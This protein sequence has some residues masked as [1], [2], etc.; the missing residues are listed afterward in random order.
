[1]SPVPRR[2]RRSSVASV[3]A[4]WLT[5]VEPNGPFLT[6]PVLR[7]VWPNGLDHLDTQARAEVR[8]HVADL[9]TADAASVTK[10]IEWVLRDLLDYGARLATGPGFPPPFST[11]SRSTPLCFGPTTR[12]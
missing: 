8:R 2:P 6:L 3:H 9:N 12:S 5:L 7:R 10:W 11:L 4:D 1:M